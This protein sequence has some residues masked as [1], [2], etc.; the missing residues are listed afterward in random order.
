MSSSLRFDAVTGLPVSDLPD[1][2]KLAAD[3]T[4]ADKAIVNAVLRARMVYDTMKLMPRNKLTR[5]EL[6]LRDTSGIIVH[7]ADHI[8]QLQEAAGDISN[9]GD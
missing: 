4:K 6:F 1:L 7:L 2:A 5:A 9:S 8:I 3:K